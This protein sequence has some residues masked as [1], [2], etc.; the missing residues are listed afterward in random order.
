MQRTLYFELIH[1]LSQFRVN[2]L[3]FDYSRVNTL[4]NNAVNM[5]FKKDTRN[6]TFSGKKRQRK[7][8]ER[9]L[10]EKISNRSELRRMLR[11]LRNLDLANL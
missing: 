6:E 2:I 3:Q 11:L 9:R 5:F 1:L 8:Y 4:D 10:S 7:C